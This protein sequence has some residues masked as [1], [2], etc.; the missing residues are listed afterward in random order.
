MRLPAGPSRAC[1]RGL[2]CSA[3][4]IIS[5]EVR[6][7]FHDWGCGEERSFCLAETRPRKGVAIGG[8]CG[9][10]DGLGESSLKFGPF[11]ARAARQ[12]NPNGV[13]SYSPGLRHRS[14]PGYG[15]KTFINLNGVVAIYSMRVIHHADGQNRRTFQRLGNRP[16]LK[17]QPTAN[18]CMME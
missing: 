1:A 16:A 10:G 9:L 5:Q 3:A 8:I 12:N 15:S 18:R 11:R 17:K 7:A 6:Q 4:L 13:A 2:T 14:Y